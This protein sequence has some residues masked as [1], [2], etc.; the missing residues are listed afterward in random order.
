[1]KSHAIR[2]ARVPARL[3]QRRAT[4]PSLERWLADADPARHGLPAQAIVFVRRLQAPWTALASREPDTRYGM[5][6]SALAGAARPARGELHGEAVWFADEAELLA[7]LARAALA[8]ELALH[9]W[10]KL[11]L[12]EPA[13]AGARARWLDGV[14]ATPRALAR[15]EPAAAARWLATWTATE[16]RRLVQGLARVFPLAQE[17]VLAGIA[18]AEGGSSVDAP[19]VSRPGVTEPA[20]AV[21]AVTASEGLGRVLLALA[22][23]PM[24]ACDAQRV[25]ALWQAAA[26]GTVALPAP[27]TVAMERVTSAAAV[28][29]AGAPPADARHA[30]LFAHAPRSGPTG[31]PPSEVAADPMPSEAAMQAAPMPAPTV[32]RVEPGE[33]PANEP[34][35]EPAWVEPPSPGFVDTAFG[36]ILFLLNAALQMG[37]YGDF[38]Q[39]RRPRA[40]DCSPWRFLLA[41][42]RLYAGRAFAD[43]PLAAWLQA[44]APQ[45]P[46][47][48]R[49]R[50]PGLWRALRE[51]LALALGLG[52][53]RE[54]VPA[55]LRLPARLADCGEH[56]DLHVDLAALPLPVRLAGLD[57]D[58][59]WI[60]AA[61]C[62]VRFHFH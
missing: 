19:G 16:Q 47:G 28:T 55:L 7:C 18:Q 20:A 17:E 6:A 52:D 32:E 45:R 33:L 27:Q 11:V 42:G 54:L 2:S 3:A 26:P 60:P 62:D 22:R 30:P 56:I 35:P 49:T 39:P 40:L 4:R 34:V 43:D 48:A 37:L 57:R 25:R 5:L 23:D 50:H 21:H 53:A 13:P 44:R 41:S 31:A 38:T 1:M 10:W 8:G 24:A 46:P 29:R 9:W 59:G 36:G 14:Q 61:G 12:R 51:R 58:P 15:L